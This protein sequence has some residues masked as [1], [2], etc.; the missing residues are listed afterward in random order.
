MEKS[1]QLRFPL[2][3]N[4]ILFQVETKVASTNLIGY[5]EKLIRKFT[6]LINQC[7]RIYIKC[8]IYMYMYIYGERERGGKENVYKYMFFT[9]IILGRKL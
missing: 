8:N 2:S 3:D 1:T 5:F 4:F 6:F 9:V 7:S